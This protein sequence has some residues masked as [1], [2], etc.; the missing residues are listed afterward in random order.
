MP[1]NREARSR[2]SWHSL[3]RG[4]GTG[5]EPD[6]TEQV[7]IMPETLWAT[8]KTFPLLLGTLCKADEAAVLPYHL[9]IRNLP[10]FTNYVI[11]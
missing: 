1:W 4:A 11:V 10:S 3:T 9:D 5:A 7:Q 2:M 8:R 6:H